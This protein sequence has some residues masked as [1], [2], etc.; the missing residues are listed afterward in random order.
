MSNRMMVQPPTRSAARPADRCRDEHVDLRS[1]SHRC[2]SPTPEVVYRRRRIAAGAL[3]ALAV[4][5]VGAT[6]VL[7]AGPGGAPA[8]AAGAAPPAPAARAVHVAHRGDT[9]WAIAHEYRGEVP[10]EAYLE[11]LIRLNGGTRIE[12]GQAVQL[13]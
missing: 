7:V 12:V 9:L 1:G 11:A 8:A 13:P 6:A 10:H 2:A 5:A 3:V 4:V